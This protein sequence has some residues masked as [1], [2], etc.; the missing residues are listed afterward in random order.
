ML[1]TFLSEFS[2]YFSIF[3][4]KKSVSRRYQKFYQIFAHYEGEKEDQGLLNYIDSKMAKNCLLAQTVPYI[5]TILLLWDNTKIN[6]YACIFK[7]SVLQLNFYTCS[8]LVRKR[9]WGLFF[10][11]YF[12]TPPTPFAIKFLYTGHVSFE[13]R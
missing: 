10:F 13:K 9:K 11:E 1:S 6:F 8:K 4:F 7:S 12:R 5:K 3:E 2:R